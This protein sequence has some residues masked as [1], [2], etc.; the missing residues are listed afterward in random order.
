MHDGQKVDCKPLHM[1][2]DKSRAVRCQRPQSPWRCPKK[3][4]MTVWPKSPKID[5]RSKP[6]PR[7]IFQY[8]HSKSGAFLSDGS[9]ALFKFCF[10]PTIPL[11]IAT[12]GPF[13]RLFLLSIT[14]A[15]P[16]P[17]ES[18]HFYISDQ[19]V[20]LLCGCISLRRPGWTAI[21]LI[22]DSFVSQQVAL[23]NLID[24]CFSSRPYEDF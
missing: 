16:T 23:P 11:I 2:H 5:Q 18:N 1:N 12:K 24:I 15:V 13:S 20:L 14:S 21:F 7:H 9:G 19:T 4:D 6:A 8:R 17:F 10:P 3:V 22:R